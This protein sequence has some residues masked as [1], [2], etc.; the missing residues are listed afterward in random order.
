MEKKVPE[1]EESEEEYS[2]SAKSEKLTSTKKSSLNF[3]NEKLNNLYSLLKGKNDN[4]VFDKEKIR[5]SES[6][7]NPLLD[8]LK[9]IDTQS[10]TLFKHS[11][12]TF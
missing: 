4:S 1:E 8:T 7:P 2:S 9:V 3:I 10:K 11:D 6:E 12:N 5:Q